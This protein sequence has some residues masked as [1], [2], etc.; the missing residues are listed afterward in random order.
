M[1]SQ[2]PT[3]YFILTFCFILFQIMKAGIGFFKVRIDYGC[4]VYV[5]MPVI[6]SG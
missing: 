4:S 1:L 2:P 5:V 6:K 3:T